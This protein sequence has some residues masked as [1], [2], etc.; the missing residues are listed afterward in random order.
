MASN[1]FFN[2]ASMKHYQGIRED[3]PALGGGK[4]VD[5]QGW[6]YAMFNF[7]PVDGR[8]YGIVGGAS[9][10]PSE[11]EHIGGGTQAHCSSSE[12]AV[13]SQAGG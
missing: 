9:A 12:E 10:R 13:G 8:Y 7:K 11:G 2:V 5:T 6:D 1:I 3:D 4:F